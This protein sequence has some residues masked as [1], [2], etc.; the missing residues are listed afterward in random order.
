MTKTSTLA[1]A[2]IF[3]AAG[4]VQA[5]DRFIPAAEAGELAVAAVGGGTLNSLELVSGGADGVQVYRMTVVNGGV[6]YEVSLNARTGEIT[7][8]SMI[9]AGAPAA[10]GGTVRHN[11][12]S[13]PSNPLVSRA[14]A[15]EI[16][17]AY[18]A[19]RGMDASFRRDSGMD[20]E[21][22]RWVWELEF[23]AGRTEIEFYIDVQTGEIVK[24]EIER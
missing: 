17:Y 21:R 23:R 6:S 16:A 12:L 7:G 22:G 14:A 10:A 8:I 13:R 1:L 18:L 9:Q 24:F 2:V 4:S 11:R 20:W 15:I 19:S 3:F 5:A